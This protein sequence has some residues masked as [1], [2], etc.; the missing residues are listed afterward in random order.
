ML[1]LLSIFPLSVMMVSDARN[2][3]VSS[4]WLSAFG[5]V[6]V[7]AG[8]VEEGWRVALINIVCNFF[9]LLV[10]GASLLVYSKIRKRSLMEMLGV[11]DVIFLAALTPTFRV[12]WYLRFLI[13]SAILAL[14]SWP[15][16][17]KMQPGLTGIP[18][19]TVFGACFIIFILFRAIYGR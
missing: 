19:V 1:G 14:L 6:I 11:G 12:E 5:L 9:V 18:L 10:M 13:V 17:R 15:L 4:W 3:T 16:F 7:V 8:V 2:R